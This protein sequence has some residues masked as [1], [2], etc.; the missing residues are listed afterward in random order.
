M[1]MKR[2]HGFS[3]IEIMLSIAIIAVLAVGV[4]MMLNNY[5]RSIELDYESKSVVSIIRKAQTY[6]ATGKDEKRWG[7][8]FA[9]DNKVILF[10]DEGG[11]Y[12]TAIYKEEYPLSS[13]VIIGSVSLN[14]GGSEI[15]FNGQNGSTSQYGNAN[16]N[17]TALTLQDS[18]NSSILVNIIVTEPGNVEI[19]KPSPAAPPAV[20]SQI[21]DLSATVSGNE[22][23]LSWSAPSNNGSTITDYKI[24]RSVVSGEETFITNVGSPSV[25]YTDI[26]IT[27]GITYFYKVSAINGI[28]EGGLSFETSVILSAPPSQITDFYAIANNAPN[29]DIYNLPKNTEATLS[30]TAP[31]ANGSAIL[32]YH[33]Y[34]STSPNPTTICNI[35]S[36]NGDNITATSFTH[37][38]ISYGTRYYY[39]VSA[40]NAIGEGPVSPETAIMAGRW[41]AG[42]CPGMQV[43][44]ADFPLGNNFEWKT[45]S[46]ACDIPQC[47]QNGGQDGD[48]LVDP[49]ANPGVD[50]SEYPAQNACKVIGGRLP[51]KS[52][53]LCMAN[54]EYTFN[55]RYEHWS[56]T[57]GSDAG[58]WIVR[59]QGYLSDNWIYDKVEPWDVR[60]V[61]STP[62]LVPS[63][64]HL[65]ALL[66]GNNQITLNWTAP[67]DNGSPITA[68]NIYRSTS[69]NHVEYLTSV[70]SNNVSYID[71][72]LINGTRYYYKITAVNAYGEGG[73]DFDFE[74]T[75]IPNPTIPSQVTGLTATSG[76]TQI[77]LNWNAPENNG[78]AI[79]NYRVYRSTIS[80][81]EVLLA[82]GGCSG[83]GNVLTCTDTGL[84]NGSRY[85]YKVAAKNAI[86][87]GSQSAE[88]SAI[89]T[90]C[91]SYTVLGTD[92]LTY[93]TV[94]GADDRCWLDR[95]LGATQIA[96]VAND[97]LSYGYYFQWGRGVDGHQIP[98]SGT[99][100]TL[101]STDNP[102]HA[103]YIITGSYPY[104]WR[105]VQNDNLWQESGGTNN[106]CPNGFRVPTQLEW[107]TLILAASITNSTSAYNSSL[108]LPLAGWRNNGDATLSD[109][110]ITGIYW[111]NSFISG[112]RQSFDLEFNSNHAY[113]EGYYYRADGFSVRCIKN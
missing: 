102:G 6:S 82:L 78:S 70:D 46:T 60:C 22:I 91:G 97:T 40:V 83:L 106:P 43:S 31:D 50:F 13:S 104:D 14:G 26:G 87:E 24:Y 47:G 81:A 99:T 86:G 67:S 56:G 71:T 108:K 94:L 76:N 107:Q 69:W 113:P 15:I 10:R 48:N 100:S 98:T 8:Y 17:S 59:N 64:I 63:I 33:I 12:A 11:G 19:N 112:L 73:I 29:T 28:G 36:P 7:V 54:Y 25:S 27:S 96:T 92:S 66:P 39:K 41:F 52:E 111:S 45:S 38:G 3:L 42:F 4:S 53:L 49:I 51:T 37:T 77:E 85:Y 21:T 68:Y 101:S 93:G 95:N 55:F 34:C 32:H 79:T 61:R 35:G 20:P 9:S 58:A 16:G 65:E 5:K 105:S 72:G 109:Q 84:F 2:K 1:K 80:G 74:T 44:P 90:D 23:V 75:A 110:G 89:S 18:Q 30:W 62:L 103:N 57:E 88:D